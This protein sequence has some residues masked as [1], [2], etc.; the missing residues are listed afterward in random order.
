[1]R[2]EPFNNWGFPIIGHSQAKQ[3]KP[4]TAKGNDYMPYDEKKTV[5][6]SK[7]QSLEL[8]TFLKISINY[9]RRYVVRLD[10]E[11]IAHGRWQS[12]G[13]SCSY[14]HYGDDRHIV[15]CVYRGLVD[16][17]DRGNFLLPPKRRKFPAGAE[18]INEWR[19]KIARESKAF[20][21][22]TPVVPI[23]I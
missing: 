15:D 3:C 19:C 7:I 6:K 17:R 8:L 9:E 23:H 21:E 18:I 14:T 4:L 10:G 22:T 13:G 1:M 5:A 11:E 16:G 20:A 12:A 2:K